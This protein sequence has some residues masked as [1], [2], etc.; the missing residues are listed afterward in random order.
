MIPVISFISSRSGMG[1]TTFLEKLIAEMKR[2]GYRIGVIKHDSHGFEMDH[3]GKDTWRHT[4]A[5]ADV[6]CISSPGKLALIKQTSQ[7]TPLADII[8]L[9]AEVDFI[10]VEG[11]KK[12]GTVRVE[13]FRG[14]AGFEPLNHPEDLFAVVTDADIY[15]GLPCFPLELPQVFADHLE[16][17]FGRP[18]P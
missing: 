1:K 14:N 5:G 15:P 8:P 11:F 7:D 13:I 10:F 16:K 18:R 4:Q 2:R 6:V 9:I 17:H 12:H 3:P